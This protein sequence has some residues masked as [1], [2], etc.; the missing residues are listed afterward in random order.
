MFVR[1]LIDEH[2]GGKRDHTMRLWELVVFER[3]QR[4]Y[5]D[6][7]VN[8]SSRSHPFVPLIEHAS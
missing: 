5:V 1:R 7:A 6:R 4:Q 3:W 2:V 8:D